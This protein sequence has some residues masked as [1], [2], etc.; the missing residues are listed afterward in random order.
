MDGLR[1]HWRSTSA[2]MKPLAPVRM[3]FM[4]VGGLGDEKAVMLL[5]LLLAI[6]AKYVRLG[7]EVGL[8]RIAMEGY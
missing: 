3:T 8:L 5:I 6:Q 2:P 1:R 7:D 4:L